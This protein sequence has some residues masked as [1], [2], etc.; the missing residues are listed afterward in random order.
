MKH[1][2]KAYKDLIDAIIAKLLI[3][4]PIS[5]S[6]LLA[7]KDGLSQIEKVMQEVMGVPSYLTKS[8][9]DCNYARDKQ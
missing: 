6:P 1:I 3:I 4:K 7:W 5:C 2:I 9:R 8:K